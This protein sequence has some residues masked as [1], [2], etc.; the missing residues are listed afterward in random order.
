MIVALRSVQSFFAKYF[1]SGKKKTFSVNTG[2]LS[3]YLGKRFRHV[4]WGKNKIC[5]TS[6]SYIAWWIWKFLLENQMARTIPVWEALET[7]GLWYEAIQFFH[8]FNSFQQ[9]RI[10]RKI[11]KISPG[12][13]IFKG[14]FWGAYFWRGLSIEKN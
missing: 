13:H 8:S 12:A 5:G 1:R 6:S 2:F 3:Q 7:K 10:Y 4:N 14:P 11:P 9:I